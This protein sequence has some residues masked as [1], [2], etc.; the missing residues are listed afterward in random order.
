MPGEVMVSDRHRLWGEGPVQVDGATGG[1]KGP[2]GFEIA[3]AVAV[4][5]LIF[6]V[7]I[8]SSRNTAAVEA[9]GARISAL[10]AEAGRH[11]AAGPGPGAASADEVRRLKARIDT[12]EK[13]IAQM[14]NGVRMRRGVPV[15]ASGELGG[16]PG[17]LAPQ[18]LQPPPEN[19]TEQ[20]LAPGQG[21]TDWANSLPPQGDLP[22]YERRISP[23]GK[24]I[25]RKLQ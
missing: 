20:L 11:A 5:L 23:D 22:R 6:A 16:G 19:A 12:L 15:P 10:E 2:T 8:H 17:Q 24:L 9:N 21:S 7:Y 4:L 3:M 14:K 1:R 25:L 13:Q 18:R